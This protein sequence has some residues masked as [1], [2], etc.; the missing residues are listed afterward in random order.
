MIVPIICH[1][2]PGLS[3]YSDKNL[4]SLL[5]FVCFRIY[6]QIYNSLRCI[7]NAILKNAH[8]CQ[9]GEPP[10]Q[11]IVDTCIHDDISKYCFMRLWAQWTIHEA[12]KGAWIANLSLANLI[13]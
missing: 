11:R 7:K 1:V 10:T 12:A 6:L 5:V 3:I 9:T 13:L 4:I 2:S 8:N